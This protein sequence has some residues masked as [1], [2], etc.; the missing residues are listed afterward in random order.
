MTLVQLLQD[1]AHN[2][3]RTG[4]NTAGTHA[5]NNFSSGTLTQLD[6]LL[7]A[8]LSKHRKSAKLFIRL[9]SYP[10]PVPAVPLNKHPSQ[11][12]ISG[13]AK[14]HASPNISLTSCVLNTS[15]PLAPL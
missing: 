1:S 14:S 12:Y 9:Y 3:T 10:A 2:L 11:A 4:S 8:Y 7:S 6:I 5:Y 13:L 15:E